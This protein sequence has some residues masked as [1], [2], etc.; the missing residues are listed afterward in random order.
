[1]AVAGLLLFLHRIL[2][3][4]PE[5]AS[6]L[7]GTNLATSPLNGLA[8]IFSYMFLEQGLFPRSAFI[9]QAAMTNLVTVSLL[10]IGLVLAIRDIRS[11][12]GRTTGVVLLI[13]TLPA[14]SVVFYAN[15]WPYA[16]VTLIPTACL[17]SGYT[18][19][20]LSH[21]RHPIL[22][23]FIVG[24]AAPVIADLW[25]LRE[26]GQES[27]RQVLSLVHQT[28]QTP[29]PYID[30]TGMI[31]S[32]PRA[33]GNL[34][35]FGLSLYNQ[36]GV[37][38]VADGIKTLRPPLLIVN[39]PVLDV[40]Q[41]ANRGLGLRLLPQDEAMLR[42]TYAP[43]WG[44]IYLA[45]KEWRNLEGGQTVDFEI[46]IP[47]EYTLVSDV[48]ATIDGEPHHAGATVILAEGPHMLEITEKTERLRLLWGRDVKV[49][50]I[51][52]S[53]QPIF[54]GF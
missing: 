17:L 33:A 41:D 38:S 52:P 13:L 32:F 7:T 39:T 1:M 4:T 37:P 34:T 47:G 23:V 49:P 10:V 43:Y 30:R 53:K 9:I 2:T 27:Q 42:A 50:A 5:A 25:T 51:E 11:G 45:G 29:V 35:Q 26:D 24:A 22:L 54:V 12:E 20:R 21:L 14:L 31:P 16:Y 3:S 19:S 48:P 6:A 18:A 40:W 15:A 28:F 46:M 8:P 36:A 44:A